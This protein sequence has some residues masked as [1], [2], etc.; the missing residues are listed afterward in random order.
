MYRPIKTTFKN[1]QTYI[2]KH[3]LQQDHIYSNKAT[4]PN[5][6]TP[7]GGHLLSNHHT[8]RGKSFTNIGPIVTPGQVVMATVFG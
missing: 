7:F 8:G 4:P 3:F 2:H 5:S 6:A 1:T